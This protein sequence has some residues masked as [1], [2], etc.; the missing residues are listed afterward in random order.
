MSRIALSMFM[1]FALA[2]CQVVICAP[3]K[4]PGSSNCKVKQSKPDSATE[5]DTL[6]AENVVDSDRNDQSNPNQ[7][8]IEDS[9]LPKRPTIPYTNWG[10]Y[11]AD[12][13]R[14]ISKAMSTTAE[15]ENWRFPTIFSVRVNRQGKVVAL[16]V[17]K[18]NNKRDT[19][20]DKPWLKK[21]YGTL[22]PLELKP[23]PEDLKL[24]HVDLQ[25][26][27]DPEP[28]RDQAMR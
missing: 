24:D 10:L 26:R 27:Y 22:K 12:L 25:V 5:K 19:N 11:R 20:D 3:N 9:L 6:F 23:F 4:R 21:L 28:D 16:E 17:L 8:D 7:I 13:K 14:A 1:C 2:N 18:R 15:V